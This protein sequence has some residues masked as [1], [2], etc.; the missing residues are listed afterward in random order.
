MTAKLGIVRSM[1]ARCAKRIRPTLSGIFSH[2]I[3][4]AMVDRAIRRSAAALPGFAASLLHVSPVPAA[5]AI[6]GHGRLANVRK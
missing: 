2:A 3:E 6:A 5:A 4:P 1:K